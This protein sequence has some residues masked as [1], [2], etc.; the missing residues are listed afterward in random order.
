MCEGI[1]SNID[2]HFLS[3]DRGICVR[4]ITNWR[5]SN[6]SEEPI[7]IF[8]P[9]EGLF[10]ETATKDEVEKALN[11][12]TIEVTKIEV[13]DVKIDGKNEKKMKID[14]KYLNV[15]PLNDNS[16]EHV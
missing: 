16:N 5:P 3:A 15:E 11:G 6:S 10:D 7:F 8:A 2:T 12:A 14:W 9:L 13:Y 4:G 1:Y